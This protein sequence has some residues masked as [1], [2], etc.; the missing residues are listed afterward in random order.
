MQPTSGNRARVWRS[1]VALAFVLIAFPVYANGEGS[2]TT[3]VPFERGPLPNPCQPS[4]QY[5]VTGNTQITIRE[6]V[7]QNGNGE[8]RRRFKS[9]G[10]GFGVPS[11]SKYLY[12]ED[13]TFVDR[14]GPQRPKTVEDRREERI[15]AQDNKVPS[16]F[17]THRFKTV[18]DEN[19]NRKVCEFREQCR[20][21][22]QDA[23][24]LDSCPDAQD[25]PCKPRAGEQSPTLLQTA[26]Q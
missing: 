1:L 20:C 15:V 4:D 6:R 14:F 17:F 21:N 25:D 22:G 11:E 19:G 13:V 16:F 5:T 8:S 24:T 26:L 18:T 7:N 12:R 3:T 2:E 23:P 9:I 10:D